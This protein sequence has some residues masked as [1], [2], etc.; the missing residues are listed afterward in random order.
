MMLQRETGE[1]FVLSTGE[2]HTIKEFIDAAIEYT[3]FVGKV[4][5]IGEGTDEKLMYGDIQLIGINP[6]Y[7]R[8]TEVD[9]LVGDYYKAKNI[10]GWNPT[11]TFKELARKMIKHDIENILK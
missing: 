6:R 10:L 9:I 4:K 2:T 3:P 5:W 11:T 8:P 1:D 7:Y